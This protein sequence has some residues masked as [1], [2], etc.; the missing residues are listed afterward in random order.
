MA[1]G[2]SSF[3]ASSRDLLDAKNADLASAHSSAG[4]PLRL[5]H[6]GMAKHHIG[7]SLAIVATKHP[8][9]TGT[10][11]SVT[12]TGDVMLIDIQ[13]NV[14]APCN[15]RQQVGLVQASPDERRGAFA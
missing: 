5:P 14:T 3:F 9:L 15:D 12:C 6:L 11:G 1:G 13:V 4:C 10:V 2:C 7:W 8:N